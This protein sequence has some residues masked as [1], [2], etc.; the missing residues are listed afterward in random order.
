MRQFQ[1]YSK[2]II[3]T[4]PALSPTK[5][6][7]RAPRC[8]LRYALHQPNLLRLAFGPVIT[9]RVLTLSWPVAC[10]RSFFSKR[11]TFGVEAHVRT[12]SEKSTNFRVKWFQI[13]ANCVRASNKRHCQA[14]L[15]EKLR[16]RC[17]DWAWI[18]VCSCCGAFAL[19]TRGRS[20]C[21][22]S[23]SSCCWRV[24]VRSDD[25]LVSLGS[26]SARS[27]FRDPGENFRQ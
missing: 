26:A 20:F 16:N 27:A 21:G 8:P 7:L 22:K 13:C 17:V 15:G 3:F 24:R 2:Y 10:H 14:Y 1:I 19:D 11:F 12:V 25:I 23:R 4:G 6:C 18:A 9:Y 5:T